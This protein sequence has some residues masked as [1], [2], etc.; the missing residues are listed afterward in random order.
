MF[1]ERD[2][3]G[4]QRDAGTQIADGDHHLAMQISGIRPHR[5]GPGEKDE[6]SR[7]DAT[8]R[9]GTEEIGPQHTPDTVQRSRIER[10][11][12]AATVGAQDAGRVPP[13]GRLWITA[14]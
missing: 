7:C 11:G 9:S 10:V 3:L 12:H 2:V 8:S 1:P 13:A 14:G 6:H 4:G 5:R